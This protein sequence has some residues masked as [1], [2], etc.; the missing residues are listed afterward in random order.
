MIDPKTIYPLTHKRVLITTMRGGG[1][2]ERKIRAHLWWVYDENR[3]I[4]TPLGAGQRVTMRLE[5]IIAIMPLEN[6]V[7]TEI[8]PASLKDAIDRQA[9]VTY[10][11]IDGSAARGH[12]KLLRV[13][14]ERLYQS[15]PSKKGIRVIPLPLIL[16][17]EVIA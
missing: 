8:N 11:R 6:E 17:V 16:Q 4:F 9:I 5:W 13:D 12:G 1:G 15:T 3:I 10:H 2:N 14:S 7:I